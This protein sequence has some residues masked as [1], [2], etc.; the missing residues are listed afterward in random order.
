MSKQ[1]ENLTGDARTR[2]FASAERNL[3]TILK[4][5]PNDAR[6]LQNLSQLKEKSGNKVSIGSKRSN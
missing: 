6:T 1:G 4:L 3:K 2:A 5:D